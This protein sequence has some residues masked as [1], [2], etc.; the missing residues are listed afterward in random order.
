MIEGSPKYHPV[1][2][3]SQRGEQ[4]PESPDND[5][6]IFGTRSIK[7]A[8]SEKQLTESLEDRQKRR[9]LIKYKWFNE[10]STIQSL[11]TSTIESQAHS[12]PATATKENNK[13][14]KK[15][16]DSNEIQTD[17]NESHVARSEMRR[18][19]LDGFIFPEYTREVMNRCILA[20]CVKK[21]FSEKPGGMFRKS[22]RL[23][24]IK[25]AIEVFSVNR[26]SNEVLN[27]P[28]GSAQ[29]FKKMH[30]THKLFTSETFVLLANVIKYEVDKPED[31]KDDEMR[32]A[33]K[34]LTKAKQN[35]TT[36]D[37]NR[38]TVSM[39]VMR[40]AY[41]H[42]PIESK[43]EDLGA[44]VSKEALAGLFA[45]SAFPHTEDMSAAYGRLEDISVAQTSKSK[46]C[47]SNTR[48]ANPLAR[49]F[50]QCTS[51]H[52]EQKKKSSKSDDRKLTSSLI[53]KDEIAHRRMI[54]EVI[55]QMSE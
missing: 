33:E 13:T 37:R 29:L 9:A 15:P 50:M 42:A 25:H 3:D 28:L 55:L 26:L 4:Q 17:I 22:I 10:F 19:L 16:A 1:I 52:S 48:R 12:L 47:S 2:H 14:H 20:D 36:D 6:Q 45:E 39:K 46:V 31:Q 23:T 49:P 35:M 21:H 18:L 5:T 53:P 51:S 8:T 7:T 11:G 34:I 38:L 41:F 54:M 43:N 24:P 32:A 27:S 44:V 40:H 30:E